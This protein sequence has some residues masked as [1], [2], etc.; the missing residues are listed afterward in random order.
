LKNTKDR[1]IRES[2]G[3][4]IQSRVEINLRALSWKVRERRLRFPSAALRSPQGHFV[5][6]L[7]DKINRKLK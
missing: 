3:E 6:T 5:S 2:K 4:E 1:S 7:D